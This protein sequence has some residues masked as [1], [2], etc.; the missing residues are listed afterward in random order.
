MWIHTT[1]M[2]SHQYVNS[3]IIRIHVIMWIH[4]SD[5]FTSLCEFIHHKNSCHCV[6]SYIRQIHISMWIHT[7]YKFTSNIMWIHT[8]RWIHAIMWI[9]TSYE[10][11]SLCEFIHHMNSLHY[12]NSYIRWIHMF[13]FT[14]LCEFTQTD[15][16]ICLNSCSLINLSGMPL[17]PREVLHLQDWELFV[18]F[19]IVKVYARHHSCILVRAIKCIAK[20]SI[21]IAMIDQLAIRGLKR[22]LLAHLNGRVA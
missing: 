14:L 20:N 9:Q 13:E 18:R 5:E 6:N 15:E 4:T 10:F 19:D 3:Y 2:N 21:T 12:V 16:F 8:I 11:T 22:S 1:P 17:A 7:S